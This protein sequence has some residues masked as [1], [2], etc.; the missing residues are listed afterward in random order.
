[1]PAT[2]AAHPFLDPALP[3]RQP[4]V[5]R[6][7]IATW[8]NLRRDPDAYRRM[9]QFYTRP[10]GLAGDE[11]RSLEGYFRDADLYLDDLLRLVPGE[12]A[13]RLRVSP[14]VREMNDL[15]PLLETT[16][17]SGHA[18]LRYEAQRKIYLA[19]LLFDID[20]SRS[21]R[22]G[23][24]H[25]EQWEA[26]LA[27][28]LWPGST[29]PGE[30]TEVVG[31]D[32]RPWRFRRRRLASRDGEREI[33]VYRYRSRFKRETEPPLDPHPA[34]G[35]L[36]VQETPRWPGLGRR[37]GSILSKM[38][39]RG[40]GDPR[41]VQDLLGAMFIVGSRGQA[42]ALE[43]RLVRLLGGPLRWRDRVDT[44]AGERDR[45]RLDPRSSAG[46]Q[47]VKQIVD[48]L[49][50]DPAGDTPYLFAV[51]VQIYPIQ[52]YLRTLQDA[53]YASHTAYKRRQ[54]LHDLL[55]ALFPPS[56][57]GPIPVVDVPEEASTDTTA[58]PS[59]S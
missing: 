34:G 17:E 50:P 13:R 6:L 28:T 45:P 38:I 43:R 57:F 3:T 2:Y 14:V 26:L 48:V 44:L 47:V 40:I 7:W 46:F 8:R 59:R 52:A 35:V 53:H 55:P 22:D 32:G 33:D 12:G 58:A 56:I 15:G 41:A 36:R 21:V 11:R 42:Y 30:D 10:A 54:F 16:F 1:V 25:K 31:E 24:R 9:V 19:K 39:R 51:E 5:A 49:M 27:E 37:S 4:A 20:H 29:D 18:R 23:L